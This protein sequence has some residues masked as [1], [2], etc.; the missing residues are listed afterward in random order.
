MTEIVTCHLCAAIW[1]VPLNH[2]RTSY[3]G[4][5]LRNHYA[6]LEAERRGA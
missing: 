6:P 5:Y 3:H 2:G 4:H 1:R